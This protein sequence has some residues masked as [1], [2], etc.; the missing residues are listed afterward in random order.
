MESTTKNL[1]ILGCI[2]KQL[3]KVVGMK[4]KNEKE[5][6]GHINNVFKRGRR[7]NGPRVKIKFL[8]LDKFSSINKY[9]SLNGINSIR[10]CSMTGNNKELKNIPLFPKIVLKLYN[11][12]QKDPHCLTPIVSNFEEITTKGKL[13]KFPNLY[14]DES[15]YVAFVKALHKRLT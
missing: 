14:R 1:N 6:L 2:A 13:R 8:G 11:E 5:L 7:F 15:Y 10:V 12:Y 9:K 4:I 3:G